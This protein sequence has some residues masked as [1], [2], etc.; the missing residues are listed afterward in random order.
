MEQE[1]ENAINTD[2]SAAGAAAAA[3][4]AFVLITVFTVIATVAAV[5]AAAAAAPAAEASVL[6]S[7]LFSYFILILIPHPLVL[8]SLDF[9][10]SSALLPS[11]SSFRP[12]A[13]N[14]TAPSIHGSPSSKAQIPSRS[15]PCTK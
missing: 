5:A 1:N 9:Y 14:S 3:A 12:P 6:I 13:P 15:I 10:L 8:G 4:A 11:F 7:C 2:A